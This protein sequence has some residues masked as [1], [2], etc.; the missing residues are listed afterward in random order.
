MKIRKNTKNTKKLRMMVAVLQICPKKHVFEK[1]C[2]NYFDFPISTEWCVFMF[3]EN[4][5]NRRFYK[6]LWC[7]IGVP[8][9]KTEPK[10]VQKKWKNSFFHVFFR[11]SVSSCSEWNNIVLYLH[12]FHQSLTTLAANGAYLIK[13]IQNARKRTLFSARVGA[14]WAK[15]PKDLPKG[16]NYL[17]L[18]APTG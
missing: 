7:S 1:K 4:C 13:M 9:D 18:S 12:T 17:K 10:K 3:S 5:Q 14:F 6:F 11:K 15:M 2:S 8:S 16:G